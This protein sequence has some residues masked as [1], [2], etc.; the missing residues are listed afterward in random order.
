MRRTILLGSVA[1]LAVLAG[2]SGQAGGATAAQ[3]SDAPSSSS[4][5]EQT[6]EAPMPPTPGI[7]Q[8]VTSGG[9]TIVVTSASVVPTITMNQTA[10]DPNS[11]SARFAAVAP[12]AGAE[13]VAVS[14]HVTNQTQASMDL[15]CSYPIANKLVNAQGQQYDAI[16]KLYQLKGNPECNAG[17]QPGF[18][19]DMTY[20]Y[21][22]P[23]GSKIVGWAFAD[24]TD[25]SVQRD[26]LAVAFSA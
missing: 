4:V 20:V 25:P 13:Y 23:V 11:S 18:S 1:A 22:V 3:S 17:L 16:E 19:G 21:A 2:C 6:T 15:T 24:A 12:P 9:V 10:T 8:P 7:G 5:A 26:Y 14:V